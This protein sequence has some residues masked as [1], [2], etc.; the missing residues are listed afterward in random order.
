MGSRRTRHCV[1]AHGP[2]I[3]TVFGG[4]RSIVEE[5]RHGNVRTFEGETVMD[6]HPGEFLTDD[7]A[8]VGL[9]LPLPGCVP[10]W[11]VQ[12]ADLEVHLGG[13]AVAKIHLDSP[14][15]EAVDLQI[16]K[17]GRHDMARGIDGPLTGNVATRNGGNH[18]VTNPDVADP[19]E[20]A[21]GIDDTTLEDDDVE[22]LD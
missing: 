6:P 22:V 11:D 18:S 21:L 7:G 13:D 9:G 16:D 15:T 1:P 4:R 17:A 3:D 2:A 5:V 10:L 19:V 14:R 20:L 12:R 8:E